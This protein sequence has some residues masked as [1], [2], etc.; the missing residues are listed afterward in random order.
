M[1]SPAVVTGNL[2]RT[3]QLSPRTTDGA[4]VVNL[5]VA[6][7]SRRLVEGEWVDGPTSAARS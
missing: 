5:T 4:P 3:P 7:N 1:S 6:A 2:T